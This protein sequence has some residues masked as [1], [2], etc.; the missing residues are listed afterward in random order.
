MPSFQRNMFILYFVA[1]IIKYRLFCPSDTGSDLNIVGY[2][3]LN[4]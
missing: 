1:W 3:I 2:R 4:T